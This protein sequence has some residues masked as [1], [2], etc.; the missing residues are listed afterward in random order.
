MSIFDV[1]YKKRFVCAFAI[2]AF[3]V[4]LVSAAF[5]GED[6]L[7]DELI[8]RQSRLETVRASFVQEKYDPMLGRP[9]KSKGAFY[10]KIGSGVRWEYEDVLVVY[11]GVVLYVYSS[12]TDEAERI[13]GKQGFMGPLAFDV[14]ELL[15]D[16]DMDASR[17]DETITVSLRPKK[18]MPFESM[19]MVFEGQEAFPSEVSI[20][21]TTGDVSAIRF[22]N[23]E[24]NTQ[25]SEDMFVFHPPPGT[26]VRERELE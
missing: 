3:A 26:A 10:F 15:K 24:I 17:G 9:I 18:D 20:T 22:S 11:D 25:F 12:E 5:A 7:L 4:F 8:E 19:E 2:A 14:K 13:K 16:Y 6:G 21:G 23:V 1:V